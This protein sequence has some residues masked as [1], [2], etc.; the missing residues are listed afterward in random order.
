MN[1]K[2]WALIGAG[3]AACVIVAAG[4][5]WGVHAGQERKR[6]LQVQQDERQTAQCLLDQSIALKA[7]L[8]TDT[9]YPGVTVLG[10][11][12][13][14][15]TRAEAE[16]TIEK[17]VDA[18]I[19]KQTMTLVYE[20]QTWTYSYAELGVSADASS[21][22]KRAYEIGRSGDLR[23]REQIVSSLQENKEDSVQI[24]T[25]YDE[26]VMRKV[27]SDLAGK[28]DQKPQDAVLQV[29][30]G[31]FSIKKEKKG[32]SLNQEQTLKDIQS[33]LK[34]GEDGTKLK[35]TVTEVEPEKTEKELSVIQ[36][37]IGNASTFYSTANY[38]REQ[39]LIVGASKLNGLLVMPDEVVSFNELV[40]PVTAENG[41]HEA[42]VIVGDEYVSDLGGGLCQVSTTLYNAVIRA[43]LEVVERDC[44][45]F[46]SDYVPMGLDAAVAQGYLDFKFKNTSGYPIYISMWA[47]GGE[48]GAAIYGKEIHDPSRTVSFDYV[49][50]DT[51]PKPE[52]K[53]TVDPTLKPG[54]RVVDSAGHTGYTV[55]VYKT[56]TENGV[57]HTEWF[58]SS[59]YM[60][61]ADKVR[62]GPDKPA[63]PPKTENSQASAPVESPDSKPEAAENSAASDSAQE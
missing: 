54:E 17:Q 63:D 28:L 35:L 5:I 33:V 2:K 62:V 60:A 57:S 21:I 19:L 49:I 53:R 34:K 8:D 3:A 58:S 45:A 14:G 32:L 16:K 20:D 39:N 22:A 51:I 44:H 7:D 10:V 12:L 31:S 26:E 59:A 6:Q 13:G 47:G 9:I 50:T 11:D 38:G 55:D 30:A 37:K 52:E 25:I 18:Q 43:E 1:H 41:Y 48:I 61:S 42:N 56:V 23:Q 27:V 46:P 40:A 36:D 15:Q 29:S 4:I 24:E